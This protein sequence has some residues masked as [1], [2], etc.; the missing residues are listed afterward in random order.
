M[1]LISLTREQ[2]SQ[3]KNPPIYNDLPSATP[4]ILLLDATFFLFPKRQYSD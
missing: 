4:G 3:Y 2:L 1:T